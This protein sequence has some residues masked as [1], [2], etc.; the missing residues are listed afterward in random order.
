M[1]SNLIECPNCKNL[2]NSSFKFCSH[3]GT[4]LS[5][6]QATVNPSPQNFGTGINNSQQGFTQGFNT[7]SQSIVNE[8]DI[9]ETYNYNIL[10]NGIEV[11]NAYFAFK[12]NQFEDAL[13]YIDQA[14]EINPNN[15]YFWSFKSIILHRLNYID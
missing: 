1:N 12:N 8:F 3:C 11:N 5:F 6:N 14:I 4:K 2:V 9:I 15:P 7:A 13:R 10:N